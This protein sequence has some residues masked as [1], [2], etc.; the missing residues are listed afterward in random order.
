VSAAIVPHNFLTISFIS[1]SKKAVIHYQI[2]ILV[3]KMLTD[4]GIVVNITSR[5]VMKSHRLSD[6]KPQL[7]V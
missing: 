7:L 2:S 6:A 5:E 3:G 1:S 4:G